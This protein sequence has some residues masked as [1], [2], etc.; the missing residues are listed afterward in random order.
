MNYELVLM[1]WV[2]SEVE[3]ETEQVEN[4]AEEVIEDHMESD[5][6]APYFIRIINVSDFSQLDEIKELAYIAIKEDLKGKIK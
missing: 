4:F 5:T 6:E 3:L 2:F 1:A